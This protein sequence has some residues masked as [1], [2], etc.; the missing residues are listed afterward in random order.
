MHILM[1]TD[2]VGGVFVYSMELSRELLARG[3]SVTLAVLG[4]PLTR[5]QRV[6]LQRMP[7]LEVEE[8]PGALEWMDGPWHD[9]AATGHRLLGI[10]ERVRPD[11]VHLNEY[12]HGALP[13]PAPVLMVGHSCVLSWWRA[14]KGEAAPER[15][16]RYREVV[17]RG[18]AG[19]ER[20]IAPSRAMLTQISR[21]YGPL[22]ASLVIPNGIELR[23]FRPE[24][25]SPLILSAGRL[26]DEAKNASALA[27]VGPRL[28]WPVYV[29]GNNEAPHGRGADV[30]GC[31]LLGPL[32]RPQLAAV[33]ARASI[34][35]LPARY[36]PFGLSILEAA[37][38]GCALVLGRV[39]SLLEHWRDVAYFVD[40]DDLDALRHTL[41][42]LIAD[43]EQRSALGR[44]AHAHAQL[45]GAQRMAAAYEREY[46]DLRRAW[47]AKEPV[48]CAS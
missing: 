6:E 22:P 16:R 35:A 34:Y 17:R 30:T 23:A 3:H 28:S 14:V 5:G 25:K 32:S 1:T 37:A 48:Q 19:A 18:I 38:S 8:L 40:P 12:A 10:A 45:F 2:C 44:R 24:D 46:L 27:A 4:G 9:V 31:E 39:P 36:E 43:P 41:E 15:Y 7:Q 47:R 11:C 21:L 29:A 13:W 42:K 20:I 33:L 26:W